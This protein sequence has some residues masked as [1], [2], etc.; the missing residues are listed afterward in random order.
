MSRRLLIVDDEPA[1]L[2]SLSRTFQRHG[3][4][5]RVANNGI[6]ALA[7]LDEFVPDVVISDHK[8]PGMTGREL[9]QVIGVRLPTT[10][11][12]LFSG[13]AVDAADDEVVFIPKPY[14]LSQLV[15]AC[16]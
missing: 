13:F 11:R 3:F 12:I 14:D 5:V 7:V 1:I 10:R 6:E 2:R 9:L 15:Q 8:M 4:E 16:R